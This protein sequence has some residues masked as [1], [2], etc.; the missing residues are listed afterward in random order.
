MRQI[1]A[2]YVMQALSGFSHGEIDMHFLNGIETAKEIVQNAPTIGGWISVKDGLP[3]RTSD[4]E[5]IFDESKEV[6]VYVPKVP[7]LLR[8]EYIAY[9]SENGNWHSDDNGWMNDFIVTH[10]MPLSEPPE[11]AKS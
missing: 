9:V 10:W 1:D 5:F 6:L 4:N 11:E 7:E 3:E 8:H 2:D